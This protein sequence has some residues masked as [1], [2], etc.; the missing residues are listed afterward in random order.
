MSAMR[1]LKVAAAAVLA[2]LLIS[3]GGAA[4]YAEGGSSEQAVTSVTESG[5][6]QNPDPDPNPNPNPDPDPNPNPDPDPDPNPNPDPDPDPNP[7]PEPDPDPNPNPNPDPDPDPNPNP[8]PDPN[9]NPNPDPDPDPTPTPEPAS[10]AASSAAPTE[11]AEIRVETGGSN[12]TRY[13]KSDTKNVQ[14]IRGQVPASVEKITVTIT[15]YGVTTT[16]TLVLDNKSAKQGKNG[17]QF[18]FP[19]TFVGSDKKTAHTYY[20]SVV[21]AYD[22]SGLISVPEYSSREPSSAEPSSANASSEVSSVRP[23][24]AVSEVIGNLSSDEISSAGSSV[25]DRFSGKNQSWLLPV[26]ILLIIL[27]AGGIGFVVWEI[28]KM[29]GVLPKSGDSADGAV[30]EDE[31]ADGFVDILGA[32]AAP[33]K[34]TAQSSPDASAPDASDPDD[35]KIDLDKF[36]NSKS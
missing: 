2:G 27:G 20:I 9:P 11:R 17:F 13:F 12:I 19:I 4:A 15:A 22:L 31:A 18:E 34:P 23:S 35:G 36:F 16:E 14:F 6:K 29:R 8:D 30:P 32:A 28:L 1:L 7:N 5:D 3:V 24:S 21:R 25:P 10:S 26:A 33:T